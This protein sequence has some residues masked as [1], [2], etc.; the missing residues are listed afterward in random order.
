[1]TSKSFRHDETGLAIP[2]K[3]E[4]YV[5]V[6]DIAAITF[7]VTPITAGPQSAAKDTGL[8]LPSGGF[9]GNTREPHR[10]ATRR[11]WPRL[12]RREP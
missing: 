8:A 1:M 4:G 6:V 9:P 2:Q 12:R 3:W 7:G 5:G 10:R 11:R